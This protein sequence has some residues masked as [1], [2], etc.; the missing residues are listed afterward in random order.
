LSWR[1][2][3]AV[4][5]GD[6]E[7]RATT[8]LGNHELSRALSREEWCLQVQLEDGLESLRR[9]FSQWSDAAWH[10]ATSAG[11]V[12]K[13]VDRSHLTR[14]CLNQLDSCLV[15]AEVGLKCPGAPARRADLLCNLLEFGICPSCDSDVRALAR[16]QEGYG[17]PDATSAAG[18]QRV[19]ADQRERRSHLRRI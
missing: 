8:R 1:R 10:A 16:E 4:D 9:G 14:C 7:N 2:V 15:A 5:R 18:D 3:D 13:D 11:V 6:V 17:P 19:L 12:D